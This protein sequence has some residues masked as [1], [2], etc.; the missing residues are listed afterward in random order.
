MPDATIFQMVRSWLRRTSSNQLLRKLREPQTV[1]TVSTTMYGVGLAAMSMAPPA[2]VLI[3]W[4]VSIAAVLITLL[5]FD[6]MVTSKVSVLDKVVASA[7]FGI[8]IFGGWAIPFVLTAEREQ[9]AAQDARVIYPVTQPHPLQG[10]V[11]QLLLINHSDRTI[12]D[13]RYSITK[14]AQRL[15]S[16]LDATPL[17]D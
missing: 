1:V 11:F 4:C 2:Y 3:K 7:V 17:R 12:Q 16:Q 8:L 5:I 13:V 10:S 9:A 15:D 6:W 14:H